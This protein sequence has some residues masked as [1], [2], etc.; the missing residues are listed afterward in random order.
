MCYL[1]HT[2]RVKG[3]DN[4]PENVDGPFIYLFRYPQGPR[5]FGKNLNYC[6]GIEHP[7]AI[8]TGFVFLN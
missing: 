1:D 2:R 6:D 5:A 7:F 8:W 3:T 4:W